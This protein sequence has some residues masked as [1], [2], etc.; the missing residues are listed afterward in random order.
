MR[1]KSKLQVVRHEGNAPE[2][3]SAVS[4]EEQSRLLDLA[5][6]ALQTKKP[7][8]KLAAGTRAHQE[9]QQLIQELKDNVDAVEDRRLHSD[10]HDAT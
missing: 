1:R 9:H 4:P 5:D 3:I 7:E 2:P 6:T 10:Q 8:V